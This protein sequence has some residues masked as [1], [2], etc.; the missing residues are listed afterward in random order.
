VVRARTAAQHGLSPSW[1]EQAER[2]HY[3]EAL[4][5]AE[6]RGFDGI[7]RQASSSDLLT[8]AEAARFAGR[9]P[10][11]EQA[12]EAVRARYARSDD[13]STAAYLLGRIAAEANRDP[14]GAAR[15]F[16]TYLA[17]RPG[18]RL[19][20]EAEGRLL[21]SL[22][23]TDLDAARKTARAYLERYPSGPHAGFAKSLLAP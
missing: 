20:R 12:L 4:S 19:E 5:E 23:S 3:R 2:G 16:R 6:R 10:R 1:R 9:V 17:E 7:C 11:A 18:G 14:G 15:W 21:E 22:A 13:A 8:L